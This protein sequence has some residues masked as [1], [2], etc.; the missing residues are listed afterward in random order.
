MLL[1]RKFI[2]FVKSGK[3]NFYLKLLLF[4]GEKKQDIYIIVRDPVACD[5]HSNWKNTFSLMVLIHQNIFPEFSPSQS[6][7]SQNSLSFPEFPWVSLS[8]PK[9][10]YFPLISRFFQVCWQ[11]CFIEKFQKD[12]SELKPC[13][14]NNRDNLTKP[15]RNVLNSLKKRD[16]IIITIANKGGA[17]V[18]ID[19]NDYLKEAH[20]QLKDEDFY[21]ELIHNPTSNHR[22]IIKEK[23]ISKQ[24]GKNL[25]NKNTQ[26]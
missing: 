17:I 13:T 4:L 1:M 15:E 2:K 23:L 18:I 20:R 7:F 14:P 24:L 10:H 19:V 5:D 22:D 6:I 12:I 8:L 21:A 16:D 25:M 3:N 11:P 9:K 26:S